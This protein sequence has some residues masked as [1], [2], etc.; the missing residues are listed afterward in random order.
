VALLRGINVGGQKKIKMDDLKAIFEQRYTGVATYIQSGNVGF[1]AG[2]LSTDLL[3]QEVE[4]LLHA[5][6]GYPVVTLVRS[7]TD[8]EEA[9]ANN[10]YDIPPTDSELKWYLYFLSDVPNADKIELLLPY[11]APQEQLLIVKENLYFLSP[12]FGK[13]KLT[14]TLIE[15]KLG[16]SCSARNWATTLRLT[17]L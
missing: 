8:I 12:A 14:N 1:D 2:E 4:A 10:P 6:L 7:R 3:R 5:N 11:A 16:V 17:T 9:I 15:R 13:T